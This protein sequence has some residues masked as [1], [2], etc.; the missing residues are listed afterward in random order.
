MV[1]AS[2]PLAAVLAGSSK[3]TYTQAHISPFHPATESQHVSIFYV[4]HVLCRLYLVKNTSF[5]H[6]ARSNVLSPRR[7]PT[8][9]SMVPTRVSTVRCH[10]ACSV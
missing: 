2:Q 3:H 1:L 7:V 6:V 9:Q 8:I 10:P 4:V 5:L